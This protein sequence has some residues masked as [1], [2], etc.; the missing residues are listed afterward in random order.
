MKRFHRRPWS[1]F[2]IAISGATGVASCSK[3]DAPAAVASAAEPIASASDPAPSPSM[4]TTS[5]VTTG[6]PPNY[7]PHPTSSA[8]TCEGCAADICPDPL[9]AM[10]DR[11]TDGKCDA[12]RACV[13]KS[14]CDKKVKE[15]DAERPGMDLRYCYCGEDFVETTVGECFLSEGKGPKAPHGAC[16]AEIEKLAGS[17]QPLEVGTN[18]FNLET[19]LGAVAQTETCEGALCYKQ[20][21]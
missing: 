18:F 5:P 1:A 4:S 9:K 10:T 13:K 8:T 16:R 6:L 14:R 12:L 21:Y 19:P 17:T 7:N 2:L 15:P 11:C 3:H 20:C